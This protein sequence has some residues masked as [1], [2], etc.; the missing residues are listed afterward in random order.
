[1][2]C[3]I[4]APRGLVPHLPLLLAFATALQA[5]VVSMSS[6]E[7]N[8]NGT[9][10]TFE[11]RIP[12]YEVAHVT[13]PQTTLL[14]QLKFSG[15]RRTSGA[16]HE[17]D[18]T[19]ICLTSYEFEKPLPDKLDVECTLFKVTVPNHVH[20]LH[21]TQGST[22]DQVVFDQTFTEGEVRFHP[23]SP[24]EI[25]VRDSLKGIGKL[26]I[27]GFLFL[28]AM[29]FAARG[30]GELALL[31]AAFMLGEW[32]ALPLAPRIPIG[33]SA[34]FLEA[35]K[36][37][38]AAYLAVDVLLLPEG[39]NRWMA[40]PILGLVHGLSYAAFPA[41]YLTGA[42][43]A[44]LVIVAAIAALAFKLPERLRWFAMIL[45]LAGSLGWFVRL[46]VVKA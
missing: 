28:A 37:L 45:I 6:G 19:S 38:T 27:P 5:H 32:A 40:V 18:G 44:Q 1:M 42:S 7:L 26:S 46:L 34:G 43:I 3:S 30:W 29:I 23:P 13:N 21:A 41:N 22:G 12:M 20:L 25:V 4:V 10:A 8:V 15:G 39:R 24:T 2:R 33:L 11:L 9:A 35:A 31:T 14:D 17:E 16:C 36:A